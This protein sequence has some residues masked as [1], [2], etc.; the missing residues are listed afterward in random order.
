MKDIEKDPTMPWN[1]KGW[2]DTFWKNKAFS[3]HAMTMIVSM[4]EKRKADKADEEASKEA[5]RR[6][7]ESY[8]NTVAMLLGLD[9]K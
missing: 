1:Q 6:A 8:V 7:D 2:L 5:K 9:K 4:D 3:D